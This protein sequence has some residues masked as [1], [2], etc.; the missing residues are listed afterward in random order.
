VKVSSEGLLVFAALCPLR[1]EA[2]LL[3]AVSLASDG[4]AL[5]PSAPG[6]R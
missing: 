4:F 1:V 3:R 2:G 5:G 6:W